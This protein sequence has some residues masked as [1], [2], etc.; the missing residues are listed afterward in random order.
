MI[1]CFGH[2]CF[3]SCR[4]PWPG[5]D[6]GK[7]EGGKDGLIVAG[8]YLSKYALGFEKKMFVWSRYVETFG[9]FRGGSQPNDHNRPG[10]SART[11]RWM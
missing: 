7:G 2:S 8:K 6:R 10:T 4:A 3:Q 11:F 1:R 9:T 5:G